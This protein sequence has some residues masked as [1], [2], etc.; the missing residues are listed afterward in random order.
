[1]S[2]LDERPGWDRVNTAVAPLQPADALDGKQPEP[3]DMCPE[4]GRWRAPYLG[5]QILELVERVAELEAAIRAHADPDRWDPKT[6]DAALWAV[7]GDD[8]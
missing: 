4:C 5:A 3:L 1:M 6:T 8:R 2:A 7:L